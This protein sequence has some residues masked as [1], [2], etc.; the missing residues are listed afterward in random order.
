MSINKFARLRFRFKAASKGKV[1]M[2]QIR[3]VKK[4][5]SVLAPAKINLSLLVA[6]KRDDGFHEVETIM[7]KVS[8]YDEI[9]IEPASKAGIELVCA[10]PCWA[11]DGNEN[12]AYRACE[13]LMQTCGCSGNI[14]LTLTKNIPAGSGLGSASSDAAAT[15]IGLNEF[16]KA[17]L[18]RAELARLAAELGS[19]VAFFL[20]GPL[21]FCTGRGEKIQKMQQFFKFSALLIL[22][23]IS[24]ST[25]RVYANYGHDGVL[26]KK[27]RAEI[28]AHIEENR[29][30]LIV[31][32]CANML[33]N[34][35]L[36]LHKELAELKTEV[37]SF[38]VGP[39]CL[40]GSGSAF[41]HI[42]QAHHKR[43]L[44]HL[45]HELQGISG[46]NCVIVSNNSW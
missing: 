27:L 13:L 25:A 18:S 12:L 6:G 20:D 38:G 5:I 33:A 2:E 45:K 30:D 3:T 42:P 4:G 23:D 31:P 41:F 44:E 15:L 39:V 29:I 14:K 8:F 10:G 43:R 22:P 46:C 21:A 9:L 11:P 7:A 17:G 16:L 40:S 1:V 37:E 35:C 32:M 34:S 26:Y 19:D 36:S 28:K 24:V